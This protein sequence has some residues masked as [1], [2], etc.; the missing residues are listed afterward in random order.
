MQ[1]CKIGRERRS[2][3]AIFR[4]P[5]TLRESVVLP[6]ATRSGSCAWLR[7]VEAQASPGSDAGA[8]HDL[9]LSPETL[10]G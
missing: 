10:D 4:D 3:S 9:S 7:M 8:A 5:R 2:V 6:D 1:G